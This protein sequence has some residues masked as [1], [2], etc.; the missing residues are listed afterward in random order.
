M[1]KIIIPLC[2][3]ILA[4]LGVFVYIHRFVN[5]STVEID[6][7]AFNSNAVFS[8]LNEEKEKEKVSLENVNVNDTIYKSNNNYYVGEEK[9]KSVNLD[10]PIVSK[11]ASTLY[12]ASNIGEY[13]A[14]DFS[15]ESSYA[16]SIIT[17]SKLYNTSDYEQA[18]DYSYY[19]VQMNNG[20]YINLSEINIKNYSYDIKIPVNSFINFKES[21][22]VFYYLYEGEYIYKSFP[23][24][25]LNDPVTMSDFTGTYGKLLTKLMI[26]KDTSSDEDENGDETGENGN[27]P[28][29]SSGGDVGDGTVS[30]ETGESA[31]EYIRKERE[32]KK[33]KE[34]PP[35]P[36][37]TIS[38]TYAKT[39][40]YRGILNISDP[41]SAISKTPQ[42]EIV[43]GDETIRKSIGSKGAYLIPGLKPNTEYKVTATYEYKRAD[44]KTGKRSIIFNGKE[45]TDN[46]KTD[47]IDKLNPIKLSIGS[48]TT[49]INS[50][51]ILSL[52]INN[53]S[54][55][56]VLN[57][58]KK[59]VI[60]TDDNNFALSTSQ[61]K[62][63]ANLSKIDYTSAKI[64]KSNTDYDAVIEFM[65]TATNGPKK[66]G[67]ILSINNNTL[68]FRT[69]QKAPAVALE[70]NTSSN[71]KVANLKIKNILNIDNVNVLKYYYNVYDD[72]GAIIPSKS[73]KQISEKQADYEISELDP[74]KKYS[75]KVFS[76][77]KT[78]EDYL[79]EDVEVG[80]IEFFSYD[81][82][83]IKSV[84]FNVDRNLSRSD[85]ITDTSASLKISSD[86]ESELYDLLDDYIIF[87]LINTS[88][89]EE[90]YR[91]S[92][93][94]DDLRGNGKI[95]NIY[96]D[97]ENKKLKSNTEYKA[98]IEAKI[99][100]GDNE[101]DLRTTI[102]EKGFT[103]NTLKL[104]PYVNLSNIFVADGYIDFDAA[105]IDPDATILGSNLKPSTTV[106]LEITNSNGGK[107]LYKT[108][109]IVNNTE[110]KLDETSNSSDDEEEN[111]S[112]SL[113]KQRIQISNLN[114]DDG[115]FTFSFKAVNYDDNVYK[116]PNVQLE[117]SRTFDLNG[118]N[119]TIEIEKVINANNYYHEEGD[120]LFNLGDLTRWKSNEASEVNTFEKINASVESNT[121]TLE[122]YNG[123]RVYSYYL[124]ELYNKKTKQGDKV[125]LSFSAKQGSE[126]PGKI[127]ILNGVMS[128]WG[129]AKIR[130]NDSNCVKVLTNEG[131]NA[132]DFTEFNNISFTMNAK[133]YISFFIDEE[134]NSLTGN[135]LI[136]KDLRIEAGEETVGTSEDV[137]EIKYYGE[138]VSTVENVNKINNEK[139]GPEVNNGDYKYY[140]SLIECKTKSCSN[141]NEYVRTNEIFDLNETTK[142]AEFSTIKKDMDYKIAFSVYDTNSKRYY[143]LSKLDFKSDS[144]IRLIESIDDFWN[145]H[146]N[147]YYISKVDLD[148]S[149]NASVYSGSFNGTLDMQGH[150]I[151][152]KTYA[153]NKGVRRY[154]F[155]TI[156]GGGVIK[157]ADVEYYFNYTSGTY[158]YGLSVYNYGTYEN[159]NVTVMESNKVSNSE[160]SLLAHANYGTMKN[161]II[162]CKEPIYGYR[163]ISLGT[164]YNYGVMKNG[165]AYADEGKYGIDVSINMPDTD[166]NTKY[167][168]VFTM[169]AETGSILENVY[170]TVNINIGTS[171][172]PK[173]LYVGNL[174]GRSNNATLRNAYVYDTTDLNESKRDTNRDIVY[175]SKVN[176]I[177]YSNLYY[178]SPTK[179][180]EE[181][182]KQQQVAA[183]KNVK[184]QNNTIN[185][186]GMFLTDLA[187]R[188]GTFPTLEMPDFMPKQTPPS[189]PDLG[190][191]GLKF[192]GVD[193]IEYVSDGK[194]EANVTL[195]FHNPSKI[196]ISSIK[197]DDISN[198]ID[199]VPSS[200]SDGITTV[201]LKLK[202]P[203]EYKSVYNLATVTTSSGSV[204]TMNANVIMDIYQRIKSLN[205][206]KNMNGNYILTQ[207]IDCSTTTCNKINTYYGKLN[208]GG[209]T[210]SNINNVAD[211]LI[212][213][214]RGTL[215]NVYIDGF[216]NKSPNYRVGIV[217]RVEA[218]GKIKDVIASNLELQSRNNNSIAYIGGLAGQ[219]ESGSI[220]DSGVNG[221]II[222]PN[223]LAESAPRIG[224]LAG[225]GGNTII[226]NSFARNITLAAESKANDD[227]GIG[228][229]IGYFGSGKIINVYATGE[230]N[231]NI[232]YLGGIAGKD[233]STTA[234]ISSAI[235]KVNI[236][237]NQ[238]YIGGIDGFVAS[239]NII[240]NTLVLGNIST[241]KGNASYVDRTSGSAIVRGKNFV[242]NKQSINNVI[243]L[244]TSGEQLLS[245]EELWIP[246]LYSGKLGFDNSWELGK[247]FEVGYIPRLKNSKGE[248]MRGQGFYEDEARDEESLSDMRILYE[249][250]FILTDYNIDKNARG[251]SYVE[252]YEGNDYY[253]TKVGVEFIFR[254]EKKYDITKIFFKN[255]DLEL[256]FKNPILTAMDYEELD[257]E[258]GEMVNYTKLEF[259]ATPHRYYDNYTIEKIEYKDDEQKT[260]DEDVSIVMSIPFY[261]RLDNVNDWAN[262]TKGYF[263][264][265]IVDKDIDFSQY[266]YYSNNAKIIA[267][268]YSKSF[269]R[270]VG[271]GD[272]QIVIKNFKG[273]STSA[274][275][276]PIDT[277]VAELTN[278]K[279]YNINISN[280]ST[281][282]YCGYIK[283]LNGMTRNVD[284]ENITVTADRAAYVGV[285]S[286]NQSPD[287]RN[288][289][290]N[291]VTVSGRT[292]VGFIGKSNPLPKTQIS[293]KDV[294]INAQDYVYNNGKSKSVSHYVGGLYGQETWKETGVY[295]T[296][297]SAD[298]ITVNN[299][300]T[301]NYTGGLF[302]YGGGSEIV[303]ANSNVNGYQYVGGISGNQSNR[304]MYYNYSLNNTVSG[305]NYVGGGFGNGS[306]YPYY[307][308]VYKTKVNASTEAGGI[309]GRASWYSPY[310]LG[311]YKN[312][313][314]AKTRAGGIMGWS[315]G[316]YI[317]YSYVKDTDVTATV[318][319]AGGILGETS[320]SNIGFHYNIIN[321]NVKATGNSAGGILGYNPNKSTTSGSYVTR[322]RYDLIVDTNVETG[323]F[324]GGLIGRTDVGLIKDENY[325]TYLDVNVKCTNE[326]A[327]NCGIVFGTGDEDNA[328]QVDRL[329]IYN[330]SK[331][332]DST[333]T[334]SSI[335]RNKYSGFVKN[336]ELRDTRLYD[337]NN[338]WD[339]L[340]M[341][342]Y[343]YNATNVKTY[344]PRPSY[345][346]T[347]D[348]TLLQV[349]QTMP[350]MIDTTNIDTADLNK[351]LREYS[352]I[353][354][355]DP[356]LQ[357]AV[358]LGNAGKYHE[359]PSAKVYSSSANTIN[360]DFSD[361]DDYTMFT[362]NGEEKGF[363]ENRTY[364]F[365][366]D[367][368][369]DFVLR[370]TDGNLVKEYKYTS[371]ELR[372][373]ISVLG[374][375]YYFIKDKNIVSNDSSVNII[376]AVNIYDNNILLEDG[377]IYDIEKGEVIAEKFTNLK[378]VDTKPLYTFKYIDEDIET[379]YSY[380]LVNGEYYDGQLFVKNDELE[381]IDSKLNN[382]K[383]KIIMDKYN[384][385]KYLLY[386]SD[387][388]SIYSLKE[389][390]R[391]PDDFINFNIVDMNSNINTNT[392][393]LFVLFE[394]GNYVVFNYKTG[395]VIASDYSN[396][397]SLFS[398]VLTNYN[399]MVNAPDLGAPAD[400]SYKEAEKLV[401][402]LNEAS[403]D[404]VMQEGTVSSEKVYQDG[405]K[406][407]YTIKYNYVTKT[408]D[409]YEIAETKYNEDNENKNSVI[410]TQ[411]S[412]PSA[413]DIIRDNEVLSDYYNINVNV[414]SFRANNSFAKIVL[415]FL[416]V[417]IA[418]SI[419]ILGNLVIKKIKFRRL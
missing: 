72:S 75:V 221:L 253:L 86:E 114:P 129:I 106:G 66:E 315:Q 165:Y 26:I 344:Y 264:N 328:K 268:L 126:R 187:W 41:C 298:N 232:N 76:N 146:Q 193:S 34:C 179:F 166:G 168:G 157:N 273:S 176:N 293:L 9:K 282:N 396:K 196:N 365:E 228:G 340:R 124:P 163:F 182:S 275:Q 289:N 361:I 258:T 353:T 160:L 185:G 52:Q 48:V 207:D 119:S 73:N 366:Y 326:N 141:D 371:D 43:G 178:F 90:E 318:D 322:I 56:E 95:V 54:D 102:N 17:D 158:N 287:I 323:D 406:S 13:I 342:G 122:A 7:Y 241:A 288:I 237:S 125:V 162:H 53:D 183:L 402:K 92:I 161:F 327:E 1:K 152:Y 77:Y 336:E 381:I 316:T 279:F 242:W 367:Y 209:H 369:S 159:I 136:I 411:L 139:N 391:Y 174:A 218:N 101:Y 85:N 147:G 397:V 211:C 414:K 309:F 321:A 358:L 45:T 3:I 131:L 194:Y 350:S 236:V 167:T 143:D 389:T 121:I 94:K 74:A 248:I 69:K 233:T 190:E 296:Y 417:V 222:N 311:S 303:I 199:G 132:D 88:T 382:K 410:V 112:N 412:S 79:F 393:L 386:L 138:F 37:V 265:Y 259:I 153:N 255:N 301:G 337:N 413:Q 238:D 154:L 21:S 364:T 260:H 334:N 219:V 96:Y 352:F 137:E 286:V 313:I 181:S 229:I 280:T 345:S 70:V 144:E 97:D 58:I 297:V 368:N 284:F 320:I 191:N 22:I 82:K 235:S 308:L 304:K 127:C 151:I 239:Q 375:N 134:D 400:L 300:G 63:L 192:I 269:N 23:I 87:R 197:I 189:L 118:L 205:E 155:H 212:N 276:T 19:F 140:V 270:L 230:I 299:T 186:D 27:D 8:N 91:E 256:D 251:V 105:V 306:G 117:G 403:I 330:K 257:P 116:A 4:A 44:G 243:T 292:Y 357:S 302:G 240:S 65:D 254:N 385:R 408:Y 348:K 216:K 317:Y 175:G 272:N 206:I 351:N 150:K 11:D 57:G 60:K 100:S 339:R 49:D 107:E 384:N 40:S 93:L 290:I 31:P 220:I 305:T 25:D 349:L 310:Y 184:F 103:F 111:E 46:F 39:Y 278:V 347:P 245:Q 416:S 405:E 285:V 227:A 234:M 210:I 67:N 202:N 215:E 244:D 68:S 15:H 36:E 362:I 172:N 225:Y 332:N 267:N 341:T 20:I 378:P 203:V 331:L 399:V 231:T 200:N 223:T 376:S 404:E 388:G 294:T 83:N 214:L 156:G 295:T 249:E 246:T 32:E 123:W 28:N 252:G 130:E 148:F 418:I 16:G 307:T 224:G 80:N 283:Y 383:D 346:Q 360:I 12:I 333:F 113:K 213:V 392:D 319:K 390:I 89:N 64:L 261:K 42:L 415:I 372:N 109:E 6:G 50:F 5:F 98:V 188:L 71:F 335:F 266:E 281:G 363:I 142:V 2:I 387:S 208:G 149:A 314:T 380:S 262:I 419:A 274:G 177:N 108:L 324:A 271:I 18:T 120:N 247:N 195:S 217:C 115:P 164:R 133:G 170:S 59:V 370:L 407:K 325:R 226:E 99:I 104:K 356:T 180:K 201:K 110:L 359:L 263:E 78:N 24:I 171:P 379:Y 377:S 84:R 10:Y 81:I 198:D 312:T 61:I 343:T 30:S 51:Y 329:W 373:R 33:E 355:P 398:Y 35:Y 55:D 354:L 145:M 291:N 62:Y 173:D 47:T 14:D 395:T 250:K 29:S 374:N 401:S 409:V 135:S 204:I 38:G 394:N 338:K 277:I 169:Q 128:N